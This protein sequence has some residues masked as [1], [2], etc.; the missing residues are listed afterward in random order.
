MSV[1]Q[2]TW[3]SNVDLTKKIRERTLRDYLVVERTFWQGSTHRIVCVEVSK[4]IKD[5]NLQKA[6][7]MVLIENPTADCSLS[8]PAILEEVAQNIPLDE[9]PE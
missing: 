7:I 2:R 3:A 5:V 4:E 1:I 9:L 8:S 6:F